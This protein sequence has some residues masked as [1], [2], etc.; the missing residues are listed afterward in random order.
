MVPHTRAVTKPEETPARLGSTSGRGC[1]GRVRRRITLGVRENVQEV[2]VGALTTGPTAGPKVH[3][4]TLS[5]AKAA[6]TDG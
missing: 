4:I 1:Q 3:L 2:F 5:G 6:C